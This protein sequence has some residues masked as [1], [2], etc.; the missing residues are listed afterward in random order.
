MSKYLSKSDFQIASSCAKKLVY[1]NGLYPTANDTNEYMKILS[2]GGYIVGKMATLLFSDGIEIEGNTQECIQQ[3]NELMKKE[4]VVLFEPAFVSGQKLIRV[5]I[6]EKKGD[7]IHLIEVKAKSH[8]TEDD[9]SKQTAIPKKYIE[10]VA[11]Q[12]LVL[13]ESFPHHSIKASLLM[14]D[15]SKRTGIEELAGWFSIRKKEKHTD[16]ELEELPAQ[17]R[18]VFNKPDV[19]FKYENNPYR[20]NF[21]SQ[22]NQESILEY[23]DVTANVE[24]IQSDILQR[25]NQFIRILNEEISASDFELSKKCKA[26]EFNTPDAAKN[27]F[28]ECWEGNAY[29]D[30]HIFDLYYGGSIGHH[31]KGFYLDELIANRKVSLFDIDLERLRNANGK[32]STRGERQI[33]QIQNTKNNAEWKSPELN[34]IVST[35]R[36]PLHF[37][38]FETYT[39]AIPFHKG[40]RP[41]EVIAF[42]WSC[43]TINNPGDTPVH[44]Q[45]IHTGE[46]FPDANAFPNFEFAKALKAQIGNTGTPLMW[47]THENTVLRAILEQMEI[48]GNDDIVLREWLIN[49]TSDIYR[50]GRLKDMNKMTIEHYF[51]PYM[52]G[53]T[54]IKKVLPAVWSH[55]NY[56]HQIDHFKKYAPERFLNGILDPYDTLRSNINDDELGDDVVNEGTAAMRAYQRIRFDDTLTT[57]QKEELRSQLLEYCKLDT[58]AMVIIAHHW[59]I[60]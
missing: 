14:P 42:Q 16:E 58:M 35:L 57:S 56:L 41:Y 18:P 4:N 31:T 46:K 19:V 50:K 23:M 13:N 37:I 33:I 27:G 2:Q 12:Y 28:Q 26:C 53:R 59:G 8:N 1:K 24:A 48:F 5:D 49:I 52:K 29:L 17:Q 22:L 60:K 11:F 7:V 30:H 36:Y 9:S 3:T 34:S 38:D 54:S 10:D 43:H 44:S 39:G 47:A 21:I 55:H 45:W 20:E 15:K 25:A 40:M 51:H 32:K 6:L